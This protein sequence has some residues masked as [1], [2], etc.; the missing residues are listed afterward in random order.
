MQRELG[1]PVELLSS[2]EV[3]E[4]EPWRDVSTLSLAAYEPESGYADP[5]AATVG[6]LDQARRHG[7]DIRTE[8]A[9]Q[10]LTHQ[11]HR[12]TGVQTNRGVTQS[13]F[14]ILTTGAWSNQLLEPLGLPYGLVP[15]QAQLSIFRWPTPVA[16]QHVCGIDTHLGIWY[17]PVGETETLVG[18]HTPFLPADLDTY[19]E[20]AGP[21]LVEPARAVIARIDPALT[22]G[23]ARGGWASVVMQS[24]D[25]RPLLVPF[26]NTKGLLSFLTTLEPHSRLHHSSGELSP[27]GSSTAD[28]VET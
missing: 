1:A 16:P 6:F 15:R 17:R 8:E 19:S 28:R 24:S 4:L 21:N 9:V 26:L 18:L 25:G 20:M 11:G 22:Y 13:P 27:S 23:I 5:V 14:I 12:T 7:T 2:Q 3:A 10:C